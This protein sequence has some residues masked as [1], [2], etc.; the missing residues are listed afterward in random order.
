[1]TH[2]IHELNYTQLPPSRASQ[3]LLYANQSTILEAQ[4]VSLNVFLYQPHSMISVK[5]SLIHSHSLHV[6]VS[7]Y[8][9][10][11]KYVSTYFKP[12]KMQCTV[13]T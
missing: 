8:H 6:L 3:K 10:H 9:P 2:P 7:S 4:S 12:F 1:M 11:V 13:F 5:K